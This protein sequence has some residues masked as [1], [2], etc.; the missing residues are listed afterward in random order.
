M[1]FNTT[2][3]TRFS[4]L[5]LLITLGI[6]W[7]TG[8]SIA[9]YATTHGVSPLGYSFWQSLGPA[10]LISA[11]AFQQK[12]SGQMSF[13]ILFYY[14]ICGMTAIA[15][16]NTT[17]YFAAPHLPASILAMVVNTVPVMVYPLALIAGLE[18]FSWQRCAG[19][20]FAILALTLIIL[21]T[22]SLPTPT[23]I[24]WVLFS[25][26]TPLSFAMCSIFIAKV[27]IPQQNSRVLA[28]GMLIASTL[29]LLPLVMSTNS[30]YL[31]HYPLT[32]PDWIILLE[33]IL[34]S[35]G[36]I[37]YFKLIKKAGPV[38]YSLVD[39]IVVIT[40]IFWGYV[41]FGEQLNAWTFL[42][43]L[44]ILIALLLVTQQQRREKLTSSVYNKA[45]TTI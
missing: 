30:F 14:I 39:S 18:T 11:F 31:I 26:I 9:R 33:I 44:F 38:Y 2:Y 42:V 43:A 21:P 19:V 17:M 5:T 45:T 41:I 28:A 36:Y 20:S 1:K 29:L 40:G 10:L 6:I 15:I 24:P 37:L 16:P 13:S 4:D 7:G 12:S 23:M 32:F 34:S 22:S 25:L 3:V 8:Y 35:L 27:R